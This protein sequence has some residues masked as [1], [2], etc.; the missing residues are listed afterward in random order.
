MKT[1]NVKN[2]YS[3]Q[4]TTVDRGRE[5]FVNSVQINCSWHTLILYGQSLQ[6]FAVVIFFKKITLEASL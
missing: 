5:E 2:S 3:P 6:I 4:A 1:Y